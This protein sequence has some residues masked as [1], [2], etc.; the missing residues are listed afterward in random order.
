MF[1]ARVNDYFRDFRNFKKFSETTPPK[2]PRVSW[3]DIFEVSREIKWGIYGRYKA[4]PWGN[5]EIFAA[6]KTIHI[7]I[8]TSVTPSCHTPLI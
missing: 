6:I 4:G 7:S 8:M 1:R 5:R 3:E 2:T